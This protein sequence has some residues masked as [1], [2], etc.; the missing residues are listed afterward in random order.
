MP[1]ISTFSAETIASTAASTSERDSLCAV[2]STLTWSAASAASNSVWSSENSGAAAA[3]ASA[4]ARRRPAA[5][6]VARRLLQLREALEAQRLRE[7][8]D[9]A[10]G[11]V[12]APGQL[13]GGLEGRLVEMVDDVL[14]DVLLRARELVE[15]GPDVG[16]QRLVAVGGLGGGGRSVMDCFIGSRLI[17]RRP[18]TFLQNRLEPIGAAPRGAFDAV[19]LLAQSPWRSWFC[20]RS[21]STWATA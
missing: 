20:L 3:G 15:A 5:V 10:R 2:S 8:H 16:G 14:G 6:L 4:V 21:A 1:A 12:G 18:A 7:A 9:R 17:R 11:G 13:L 19:L